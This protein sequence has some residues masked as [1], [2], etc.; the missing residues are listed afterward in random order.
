M[1]W[2]GRCNN[3]WFDAIWHRQS[4]T[5][6]V[7]CWW[8]AENDINATPSVMSMYSLHWWHNHVTCIVCPSTALAFVNKMSEKCKSTSHSAIQVIFDVIS[9]LEKVNKLL[10]YA[11]MLDSL[12]FVYMQFVIMLIELWKVLSQ[13]LKCLC[14]KTT[15][16]LSVWTIPKTMDVNPLHYYCI[17]NK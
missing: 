9:W 6:L 11:E 8:I 3:I 1:I 12:V 10:T 15:T 16:V 13:E 5:T 4:V 7:L 17:R 14:R 2:H